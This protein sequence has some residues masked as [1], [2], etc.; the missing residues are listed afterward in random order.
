MW[1][2]IPRKC[3]RCRGLTGSVNLSIGMNAPGNYQI[4][5]GG[6]GMPSRERSWN[7]SYY[8]LWTDDRTSESKPQFASNARPGI[9][10]GTKFEEQGHT[11]LS[12]SAERRT[13]GPSPHH[14]I[15]VHVLRAAIQIITNEVRSNPFVPVRIDSG[16][17]V[18][19]DIPEGRYGKI[20]VPP[21]PPSHPSSKGRMMA[22]SIYA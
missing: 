5:Y 13:R 12:K 19:V 22:I 2:P 21:S 6:L 7:G 20:D 16:E 3:I 18:E 14:H 8:P 11:G 10:R 1:A 15:N 17:A 4:I 9:D